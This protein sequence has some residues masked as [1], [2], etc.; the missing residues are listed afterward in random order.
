MSEFQVVDLLYLT[1]C[2]APIVYAILAGLAKPKGKIS[3]PKIT[4]KLM[5]LFMGHGT[6][7]QEIY[8]YILSK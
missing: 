3:N 2:A 7:F 8:K 6:R 5:T 4:L 1:V